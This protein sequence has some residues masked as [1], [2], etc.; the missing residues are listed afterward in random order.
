MS[1]MQEKIY[2]RRKTP[3]PK[4]LFA[5]MRNPLSARNAK[6]DTAC[7]QS[8]ENTVIKFNV[9]M[10]PRPAPRA[11]SN[12]KQRYSPKWS[13][14]FKD[15][16]ATYAKQAMQGQAPLTGAIS[17]VAEFYKPRPK[18]PKSVKYGDIDNLIKAIMDTLQGICYE[19]DAQVTQIFYASKNHGEPNIFIELE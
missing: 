1:A 9:P 5:R 3:T 17:L 7:R 4:I 14:E 18:D 16:V 12:E 11:D 15:T 8:R 10:T 19:N 2:S 6:N 13:R